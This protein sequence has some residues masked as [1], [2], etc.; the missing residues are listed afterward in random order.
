LRRF[1]AA[2]REVH[3]VPP[4]WAHALPDD[5]VVCRCEEVTAGT[6]RATVRELGASDLRSTKLL[7]R[8]G[9][10]LCQGRMCADAVRDVLTAELGAVPPDA[11]TPPSRPLAEPVELGAL[12]R[13]AS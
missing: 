6:V 9:M 10:G 12:A 13:G 8:T 1:A 3:R 2:L 5:V 7:C 11:G 4:E